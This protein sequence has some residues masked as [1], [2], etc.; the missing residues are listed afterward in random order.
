[1]TRE[2]AEKIVELIEELIDRNTDPDSGS[3]YDMRDSA[4]TIRKKLIEELEKINAKD[5]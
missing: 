1:M 2:Q 5:A 3:E 4:Y